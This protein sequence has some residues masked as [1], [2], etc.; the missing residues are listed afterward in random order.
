MKTERSLSHRLNQTGEKNGMWKGGKSI[1][2]N[3]YVLIRVGKGH[4]LAD[5]RGYAYEHRLVAEHM[6]G[7][8]LEPGEI[9]HH[10]NGDKT[11]NRPCNLEVVV[12]NAEHSARHRK[13]DRGLRLPNEDNPVVECACG[14]GER[15]LKFDAS[16]RPRKFKSGHNGQSNL[17]A[18]VLD[19]LV[20]VPESGRTRFIAEFLGAHEGSVRNALTKLRKRGQVALL[21]NEWSAV[22]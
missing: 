19:Y 9:V 17:V 8:C 7:R 3:G 5:V 16:G 21:N 10:V 14:C 11:D 6:L 2:S 13:Y 4:H 1:A 20:F 22:T 12:G 15:L 18:Q